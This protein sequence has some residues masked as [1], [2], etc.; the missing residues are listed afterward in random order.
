MGTVHS[1]NPFIAGLWILVVSIGAC[2]SDAASEGGGAQHSDRGTD[3]GRDGS[4]ADADS[5][6]EGAFDNTS[7]EGDLAPI[8]DCEAEE[9]SLECFCTLAPCPTFADAVE[10]TCEGGRSS[11]TSIVRRCGYERIVDEDNGLST[12]TL[13]YDAETLQ[14]IAGSFH[15][16]INFGTCERNA[17]RTTTPAGLTDCAGLV[18]CDPCDARDDDAGVGS[19]RE[20][21]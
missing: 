12:R 5:G 8:C 18:N 1:F 7:S 2:S 19:C 15:D 16:D 6:L 10:S 17:Y 21:P 3:L 9:V 14:L 4:V 11:S 20:S 13:V